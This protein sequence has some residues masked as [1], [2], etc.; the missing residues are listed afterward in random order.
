MNLFKEIIF[1]GT[2]IS[3]VLG[4]G[5]YTYLFPLYYFLFMKKLDK[6][7]LNTKAVEH[8]FFP[9][10]IFLRMMFYCSSIV[11]QKIALKGAL[12]DQ[13]F[14]GDY[15]RNHC[16]TLQILLAHYCAI[17]ISIAILFIV[18]ATIFDFVIVPLAGISPI[19]GNASPS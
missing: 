13:F 6:Y 1:W 18:I 9:K 5:S 7:Y 8:P 17:T 14:E 4:I 15:P 19:F 10:S 16:S 11:F 12:N 3:G 2:A